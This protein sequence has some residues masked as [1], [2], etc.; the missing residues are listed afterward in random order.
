MKK[1]VNII[2]QICKYTA[3]KQNVGE[4]KKGHLIVILV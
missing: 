3:A 4:K 1:N 2:L